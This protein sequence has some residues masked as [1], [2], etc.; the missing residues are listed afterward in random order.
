MFLYFFEHLKLDL[1][2]LYENIKYGHQK[3][4]NNQNLEDDYQL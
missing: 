4:L 2:C 3:D 1:E